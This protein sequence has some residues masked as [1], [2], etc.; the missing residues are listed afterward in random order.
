[1]I[2]AKRSGDCNKKRPRIEESV[3]FRRPDFDSIQDFF[4]DFTKP[5]NYGFSRAAHVP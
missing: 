3:T 2:I 1:M 4:V 5:K